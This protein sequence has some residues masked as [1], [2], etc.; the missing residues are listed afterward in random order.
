[1]LQERYEPEHGRT[2]DD[3][4]GFSTKVEEDM[5]DNNHYLLGGLMYHAIRCVTRNSCFISSSVMI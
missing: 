4:G 5:L 1:M 2:R 3:T